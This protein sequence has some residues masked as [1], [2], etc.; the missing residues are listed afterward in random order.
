MLKTV[1]SS[2]SARIDTLET[3]V[4]ALE[5]ASS[6]GLTFDATTT[7]PIV[8]GML[9]VL[10]STIVDGV[11]HFKDVVVAA[12]TVG[13]HENPV[14]IT[15]YDTATG[16]PYC[17]KV[18]N[19]VTVNVPGKCGEQTSA[20]APSAPVI[21]SGTSATMA[22]S[23]PS[24]DTATSTPSSDTASSTPATD[25]APSTPPDTGTANASSGTDTSSA[26]SDAPT[27]TS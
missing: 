23:T 4:L 3:R 25:T 14:G 24:T 19:G 20:P 5:N 9:A 12:L 7:N 2:T 13:S 16:N 1:A 8:S 27:T 26:S 22:S 10:G 17:F 11:T 15:I 18:T 21:S 6:T